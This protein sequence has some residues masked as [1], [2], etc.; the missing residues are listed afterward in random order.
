MPQGVFNVVVLGNTGVGKSSLLNMLAGADAF[1]VGDGAISETS[2]TNARHLHPSIHERTQRPI[3]ELVPSYCDGR[4]IE[5]TNNEMEEVS[6]E[7]QPS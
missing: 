2:L 1:K 4:T 5:A 3:D 7:K 6:L